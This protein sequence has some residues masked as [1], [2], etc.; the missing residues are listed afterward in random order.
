[1]HS[2]LDNQHTPLSEKRTQLIV[3]TLLCLMPIV[4]MAVDLVAPSL[5][6]IATGL[7][8]SSKIAQDVISIYLMGYAFGNFFTGIL[9]DSLGRRTL[10]RLALLGFVL[11]SLMPTIFPRI[12]VLLLARFLQG[13][14]IGSVAVLVRAI[15]SDILPSEKLIRLGTLIGTMFGLGPV[16]G[17]VIGGYL[18]FYLGWKAG[19]YFFALI[20]FVGFIATLINIPETHFK[21]HPL[22]IKTVKQNL[23]EVLSHRLFMAITLLMGLAYSLIMVFNTA[24]PF[25]IQKT[26]HYSSI[27][28]GHIALGLGLA[29][30]FATFVCRFLLKKYHFEQ[31]IFILIHL[32]FCFSVALL[33]ISYFFNQ[34]VLVLGAGSAVMFFACGFIF[35]MSMGKGQSLFRH[36]AGSAAALMYIINISMTSATTFLIGFL[37]IQDVSSMMWVYTLLLFMGILTYWIGIRK[38]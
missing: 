14:T 18:Q 23:I 17:P 33:S 34:S 13:L 24:G 7:Q 26:L 9:T 31:L 1:M 30:L 10:I 35:P 36:I 2:I 16:I 19:F 21:R 25:L 27:F 28:F 5:P 4:G 12:E 8:V 37:N 15:M 29:F 38:K 11:V 3:W 22:N 20:S 6:A 32:F